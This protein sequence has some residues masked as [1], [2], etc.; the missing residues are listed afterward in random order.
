MCFPNVLCLR[1]SN[2]HGI[3]FGDFCFLFG[4]RVGWAPPVKEGCRMPPTI[5]LRSNEN[6][7]F[8]REFDIELSSTESDVLLSSVVKKML[9]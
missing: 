3:S 7:V 1:F 4:W 2:G 8:R 5:E 6:V 9:F